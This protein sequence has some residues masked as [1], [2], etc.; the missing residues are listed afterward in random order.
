MALFLYHKTVQIYGSARKL[1]L[2]KSHALDNSSTFLIRIRL[3]LCK[4][5]VMPNLS[6]RL[7]IL[8]LLLFGIFLCGAMQFVITSLVTKTLQTKPLL[9]RATLVRTHSW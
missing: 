2:R 8:G 1:T 6:L 3:P 7:R 4:Q 5:E 9:I